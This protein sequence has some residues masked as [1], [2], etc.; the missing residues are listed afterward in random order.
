[1]VAFTALAGSFS[2]RAA[3]EVDPGFDP[4]LITFDYI[5]QFTLER[6]TA[7]RVVVQADG[8]ILVAGNFGAVNRS[9]R[10]G[11]ARFNADGSFDTTFNPP[12][13]VKA[14]GTTFF[15]IYALALQA[16]GKIL[17][18]GAFNTAGPVL[19]RDIMRLNTDGSLDASFNI[20][21][22]G[23]SSGGTVRD[24]FVA[25]D[26]KITIG[27]NYSVVVNSPS[28]TRA[29]VVRFF[30]D[31]TLDTAFNSQVPQS[32]GTNGVFDVFVQADGKTIVS[33]Q[34][35]N[36]NTGVVYR[37]NS[38]GSIDFSRAIRGLV[39]SAAV[40]ADGKI[41][42]GGGFDQVDGFPIPYGLI[43]L[44]ADGNIDTSF[45][46]TN[47]GASGSVN[48]I[49]ILPNGKIVIGGSFQSYNGA[50]RMNVGLLNT[51]GSLDNSAYNY[52]GSPR[53]ANDL[54][55]Q[56]DG[57]VVIVSFASSNDIS[58]VLTQP[59]ARLNTDGSVDASLQP[60]VS[61]TGRGS[62]V[63]VQPDGKILIGGYF[64]HVGTSSRYI[65]MARLNADGTV[66]S[67]FMPSYYDEGQEVSEIS[68]QPDGKILVGGLISNGTRLNPDGTFDRTFANT[69]NPRNLRYLPTGKILSAGGLVYR[70]SLAGG[71]EG[72]GITC[73]NQGGS[74]YRLAVQPDNK[75]IIVGSFTQIN[76]S[77]ARNRIA[78]LNSDGTLDTTFD[79]LGTNNTIT[80][81]EL[82]ADGKI[83][84]SGPFTSVSGNSNFKYLARLNADG[85]LDPTFNPV[86]NA[87]VSIIKMQPD[88]KIL[89]GGAFTLVNGF[90]RN[91]LVRLTQTGAV[92]NSL[93]LGSGTDGLIRSIDIQADSN[94][95]IA[96]DFRH[97]NGVERMGVARLLN[98][99]VASSKPFDYDGDGKADI[100]VFRPSENRWYIFRSSD[101][102]VTQS[103]F[104]IA[105]DI[106][107]P[108]DYDGD[109]KTDVAIYRPSSGAWWYLSSINGAQITVQWGGESGDIPRPSDFDG[110]GRTDF[111]FYR[112]NNRTWYRI[113]GVTGAVSNVNFGLAGDK[114]V[115]GDFD[116]DGKSDVA[117]YRPSDGN[118]W[119]QS[120]VDNV[121]RATRWGIPTDVPA[122]A[123][124]DGD[125]KTDFCV[126]RPSTGVWYIY[127][128]ATGTPTIGPF[129]LSEDKP[130]PA[131]YDGDGKADIAVFRPSSGI[132]YQLRST[133]GFSAFQFGVST[134]VPTPNSF[135]P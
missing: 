22:S 119:W 101:S 10:D 46:I 5:S 61:N 120:S 71:F 45:N 115:T 91:S 33:Y 11:V 19:R 63:F 44:T 49:E 50:A 97:V 105:G 129:G 52:T 24:I 35:Q 57:R 83:I 81:V 30:S 132:W 14:D 23:Q 37:L 40:Q 58:G 98:T 6:T 66:D 74:V 104:A 88:G 73:G 41:L 133:Q 85:T 25:A 72:Q 116:G 124:F 2:V 12:S 62:K 111:V 59:I 16:D 38:N 103:V 112:T 47:S 31:G 86:L 117:I 122:P 55:V 26:G 90:A 64:S 100:S 78:R 27:G 4:G 128:S 87:E 114:P 109:R 36:G 3:G 68:T 65:D 89:A 29:N 125:G 93:S 69:P 60:F 51:D 34:Y 82:Q 20:S 130:V 70:F 135:V 84:I 56:S 13:L 99:A 94:I 54:A 67:T 126:Y 121:Q 131:D 80:N 9:V 39:V 134:D 118:W 127:N 95:V 77:V 75:I 17:V 42:L 110:D 18:G 123:D 96:G 21:G 1:M 79:A 48:D 28:A 32:P 106:P 43:R 7:R 15:N 8:K 76:N 107:V 113:S 102:A 108:A 92:D 53:A